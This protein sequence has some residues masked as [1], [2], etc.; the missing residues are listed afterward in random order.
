MAPICRQLARRLATAACALTVGAA[1]IP[2]RRR[3]FGHRRLR[4]PR[5]PHPP[6]VRQ[7]HGRQRLRR[8]Q[9]L[10]RA[11]ATR[12]LPATATS[13]QSA[14]ATLRAT[15]TL[16][17]AATATPTARDR[18]RASDR[19]ADGVCN[20]YAG[21]DLYADADL[22]A[23]SARDRHAARV[24]IHP[25]SVS[26]TASVEPELTVLV[27]RFRLHLGPDQN[28]PVVTRADCATRSCASRRK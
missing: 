21:G 5:R 7:P 28:F 13:T 26:P 6:F 19:Y 20:C 9:R 3:R 8:R 24:D 27:D 10:H 25:H 14:T 2:S 12:T 15:A 4:L 22:Y 23:D 11:T 1:V 17:K 16:T 18:N